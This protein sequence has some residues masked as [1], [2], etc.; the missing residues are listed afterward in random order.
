MINM[1]ITLKG[2]ETNSVR[3]CW[4]NPSVSGHGRVASTCVYDNGHSDFIKP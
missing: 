1:K 3:G 4:L 2:F